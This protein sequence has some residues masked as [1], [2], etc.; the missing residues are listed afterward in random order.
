M[1]S[2]ERATPRPTP[3]ARRIL[4]MGG[5]INN[6]YAGQ[7]PSPDLFLGGVTMAKVSALIL[8][9]SPLTTPTRRWS[10]STGWFR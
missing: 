3:S 10:R 6:T 4:A 7:G 5:L 1:R 8:T 9:R 2:M